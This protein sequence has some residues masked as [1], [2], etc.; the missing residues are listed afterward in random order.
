MIELFKLARR[1]E[2]SVFSDQSVRAATSLIKKERLPG[3]VVLEEEMIQGVISQI[4]LAVSH[5][6]RLVVDCPIQKTSLLPESMGIE[7]AWKIMREEK[8]GIHPVVNDTGS[9]KGLISIEDLL[10]YI[11]QEDISLESITPSSQD[12]TILVVDDSA[13]VV[14]SL[15]RTL[16]GAGYKIET[17]SSGNRTLEIINSGDLDL[18]LLDVH[19]PGMSGYE[20]LKKIKAAPE[21]RGIPV[22]ML[23]AMSDVEN[24]IKAFEEGADDYLLKPYHQKELLIR[25]EN[26]LKSRS[27]YHELKKTTE[28]RKHYLSRLYELQEFNERVIENMGSGLLVM[29]L[30]ENILEINQA[31]LNI[32]RIPLAS[33]VTGNNIKDI[34]PVLQAFLEVE[35]GLASSQEIEYPVS[36]KLSIHLSFSSSYLRAQ[37][38]KNE[39]I[40]TIFRDLTARKKAENDLRKSEET[41]RALMNAT[42]ERI[43]LHKPDGTIL[44]CNETFARSLEKN[45]DELKGTCIWDYF[46]AKIFEQRKVHVDNLVIT[47]EPVHFK[48]MCNG[49]YLET[50]MYPVC[51]DKGEVESV[52]S[53]SRD[54]TDTKLA[55]MSLYQKQAETLRLKG[56]LKSVMDNMMTGL[57]VTDN[58]GKIMM[59][60]RS[61]LEILG[62]TEEETLE[63]PIEELSPNLSIFREFRE[64]V[65]PSGIGQEVSVTTADG[66]EVPLGFTSTRLLDPEGRKIG[67]VTVFKDLTEVKEIQRQ[68]RVK[69]KLATIGEV[70]GAIAH[71]I[72]NPLFSISASIQT[73]ER[74]VR[75]LSKRNSGISEDTAARLF[76]ILYKETERINRLIKSLSLI[77]KEQELKPEEIR[78]AELIEFIVGSNKGLI[79]QKGL[80]VDK[81]FPEQLPLLQADRDKLLQVIENLFLNAVAFS[82]A[83]GVIS[84]SISLLSRG[85][86]LEIT[87]GDQG[88]GIPEENLERV[89][90]PFFSTRQG[91]SGFGL[92]ISRKLIELH[93]GTIIAKNKQEG[94]SLFSVTIPIRRNSL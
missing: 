64:Q 41:L 94:G 71:E 92:A 22:I 46:S 68:L 60:N 7:S 25:I 87:I 50:S 18:I 17:A 3:L 63:R 69:E 35:E 42:T 2:I 88:P 38:G 8:V 13:V 1:G 74:D 29:D 67:V 85:S 66:L 21:T 57:L 5:P 51:N 84:L 70:S 86:L 75:N 20:V 30:D 56:L 91:G 53:F 79:S 72:K 54:V 39:G 40:I 15:T 33:A 52:A 6:D 48:D 81:D 32:L 44:A 76:S 80:T 61:A 83:G 31:G 37:D 27:L 62:V 78:P 55:E 16:Q 11:I 14:Q 89:F 23:T 49:R 19:M 58:D 82:P 4:D 9:L 28:E 43:I 26:L 73:L 34:H 59:I 77:G 36:E 12:R 90:D 24:R 10:W 47:K 45:P 65:S 93:G